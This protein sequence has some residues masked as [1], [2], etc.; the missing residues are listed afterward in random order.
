MLAGQLMDAS[1]DLVPSSIL[2]NPIEESMVL[3][4]RHIREQSESLTRN[5]MADKLSN[6]YVSSC[7]IFL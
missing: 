7:C 4:G 1:A 6:E 3:V 2:P 5:N